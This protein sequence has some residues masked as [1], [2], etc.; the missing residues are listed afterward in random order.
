LTKR[1]LKNLKIGGVNTL[2]GEEKDI[3]L[4]VSESY[5]GRSETLSVR[6]SRAI[7][8]GPIVFLTGVVHGDELR[9]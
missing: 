4:K 1:H 2:P 7:D 3:K 9:D 6:V 8:P 5:T